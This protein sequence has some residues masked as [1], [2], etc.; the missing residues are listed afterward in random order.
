METDEI[1]RERVEDRPI[2]DSGRGSENP[3]DLFLG[4]F[5]GCISAL[6]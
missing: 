4:I 5:L 2:R 1:L 3:Y 6:Q